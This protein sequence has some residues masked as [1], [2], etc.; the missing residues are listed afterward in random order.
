MVNLYIPLKLTYIAEYRCKVWI[1]SRN[2]K[3]NDIQVKNNS[4]QSNDVVKIRTG[5]TNKSVIDGIDI[6]CGFKIKIEKQT[7]FFC[8]KSSVNNRHAT[9]NTSP[10]V[11][12]ITYTT[13]RAIDTVTIFS[14]GIPS[15]G[16]PSEIISES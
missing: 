12:K 16:I 4:S 13:V 14:I 9:A 1:G 8:L 11:A 7:Y 6:I 15:L 10:A 3:G 5:Q 2:D